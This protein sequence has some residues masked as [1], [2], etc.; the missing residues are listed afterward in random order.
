MLTDDPPGLDLPR[1]RS[2]LDREAPG[3]VRGQLT[4]QLLPGGRSNLTYLLADDAHQWVLRRP[5]LGHVLATAHDMARE[6]TALTALGP[7]GIPVP[8]TVLYCADPQVL[9][10]PFYLMEHA[11]GNIYRTAAQTRGLGPERSAGIAHDLVDVLTR[12]HQ[13]DPAAVGL[14][15]FGRP[16]GFLARQ[17]SRWKRQFDASTTRSLPDADRLCTA[18]AARVPDHPRTALLHGDFRLDNVVIADNGRISAVLDWEMSTLGDPLTDFGL[19]LVY[20]AALG[21]AE[22]GRAEVWA[23]PQAGFPSGADLAARYAERCGADLE[24]LDWYV[25]FAFYKLAAI[26]EGIHSRYLAGQTVGAGFDQ[27][28]ASV[29]PLIAAGAV[30]LDRDTARA[31]LR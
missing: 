31:A 20:Y 15:G 11:A 9:G 7:T 23:S 21:G 25:A 5:P 12:I 1:L 8:A 14:T 30:A 13:V 6:H 29:S 4:A 2:H 3:L 22:P 17:V 27:V 24:R 26:T 18:L 19:F 16:E 28:G 10:A